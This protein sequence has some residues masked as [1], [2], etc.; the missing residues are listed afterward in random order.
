MRNR[1]HRP[2]RIQ[3][4]DRQHIRK[5]CTGP[6]RLMLPLDAFSKDPQGPL[7]LCR[8]CRWCRRERRAGIALRK[9]GRAA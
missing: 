1:K 3:R 5:G 6:C 2:V 4:L 9:A 8:E 7:G